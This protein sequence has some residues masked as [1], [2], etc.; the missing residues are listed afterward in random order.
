MTLV[1]TELSLPTP[2]PAPAS[3][4]PQQAPLWAWSRML[5]AQLTS[6]PFPAMEV[7][8]FAFFNVEP[9]PLAVS[10]SGAFGTS[11]VRHHSL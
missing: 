3:T 8:R 6:A 1:C 7:L 2:T 11:T 5:V 4:C 10:G 9:N